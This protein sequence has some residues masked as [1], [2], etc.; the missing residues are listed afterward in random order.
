MQEVLDAQLAD[1]KAGLG[2]AWAHIGVG[3]DDGARAGEYNPVLFQPARARLLRQQT[4]WLSPTPEVPSF[5]WR[6]GSRRVITAGVFE[7]AVTGR[8]FIAANTHLDNASAEARTEGVG[9]VLRTLR[10][11]R[12][13]WGPLAVSLTG[14]FNSS[15][16]K[17][18]YGALEASGFVRE[19][20]VAAGPRRRFGPYETYTGFED[21][22]RHTRIDF[23]WLGPTREEEG[24]DEDETKWAVERYEV[25]SNVRDGVHISDH[26][27]VLGDLRLAG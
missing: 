8:R 26:R 12:E 25:V 5:G 11:L 18:A 20:Y 2:P 27:P 7:H 21:E 15:P 6:A 10:R 24:E 9:V 23:A 14:D 22:D 17:G 4:R 19:L 16:G 1:I 13:E 3:R